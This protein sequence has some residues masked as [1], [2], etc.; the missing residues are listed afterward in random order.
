MSE[1]VEYRDRIQEGRTR[2]VGK[3]E[4]MERRKEKREKREDRDE[5]RIREREKTKRD[6]NRTCISF[7]CLSCDASLCV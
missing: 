7:S 5:T 2:R 4:R 1:C 3:R 6:I